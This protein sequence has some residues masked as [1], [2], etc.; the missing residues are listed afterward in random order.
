MLPFSVLFV[1][2]KLYRAK[3]FS[4]ILTNLPKKKT[5]Y[6]QTKQLRQNLITALTIWEQLSRKKVSGPNFIVNRKF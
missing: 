2:K 5:G 1:N 6:N 3:A 4:G